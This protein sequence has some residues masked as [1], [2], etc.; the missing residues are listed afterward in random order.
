MHNKYTI[1]GFPAHEAKEIKGKIAQQLGQACVDLVHRDIKTKVKGY[2]SIHYIRRL[3]IKSDWDTF[4]KSLDAFRR[5]FN[6]KPIS[7]IMKEVSDV[8]VNQNLI[9]ESFDAFELT[10]P[11]IE[12]IYE[13]RNLTKESF[14]MES[15]KFMSAWK[16][17][18]E[19]LF[20]IL[21]TRPRETKEE[22][23]VT[24]SNDQAGQDYA[25]VEEAEIAAKVE[26]STE[27]EKQKPT[28][29]TEVYTKAECIKTLRILATEKGNHKA[30]SVL[31]EL[32]ADN[33]SVLDE[34]K[35]PEFMK[36]ANAAVK[37]D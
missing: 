24:V 13:N 21:D 25:T 34:S 7:E 14:T 6:H 16:I 3:M 29:S 28:V 19:A 20:E 30:K 9:R 2:D 35:Y 11:E 4:I 26:L 23:R 5:T 33:L 37:E 10:V 8:L 32:G 12:K 36:L 22:C 1:G 27:V 17:I 18:G 15:K 31:K